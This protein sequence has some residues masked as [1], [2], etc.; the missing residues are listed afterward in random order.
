VVA[1]EEP[2]LRRRFG[3]L[4]SDYCNGVNRWWPRKPR[5]ALQTAPPFAIGQK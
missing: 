1:Y 4:Y 2:V 5:P 3:A